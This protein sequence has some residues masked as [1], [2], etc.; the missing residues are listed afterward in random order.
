MQWLLR[1]FSEHGARFS[2][3]L[4]FEYRVADMRWTGV[5]LDIF[6]MFVFAV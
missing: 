2:G 3:V 1:I 5:F 4:I 6:V